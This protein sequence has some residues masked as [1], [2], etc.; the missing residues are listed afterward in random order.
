MD[1]LLQTAHVE[2]DVDAQLV[3]HLHVDVGRGELLEAL[4]C[5]GDVVGSGRQRQ[6]PVGTVGGGIGRAR[7][8]GFGIRGHDVRAGDDGVGSVADDAE[9]GASDVRH[10]RMRAKQG[11]RQLENAVMVVET[12]T[13][14]AGES[15]F[16]PPGSMQYIPAGFPMQQSL[17]ARGPTWTSVR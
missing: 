5:G 14:N 3:V 4:G 8:I 17:E 7:Q 6:N 2:R 11:K 10:R 12:A 9:N 16:L 13:T 15:S 1:L